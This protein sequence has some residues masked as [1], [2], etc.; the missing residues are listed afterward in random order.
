MRIIFVIFAV[1]NEWLLQQRT[2]ASFIGWGKKPP[3]GVNSTKCH[4]PKF[5][6][7]VFSKK[8]QGNIYPNFQ[9]SKRT[10]ISVD[11]QIY[12]KIVLP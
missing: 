11:L 6:N 7:P 12:R 10:R 5:L 9:G 8:S 2:E 4:T 3:K 1:F